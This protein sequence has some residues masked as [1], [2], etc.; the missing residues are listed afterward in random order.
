M[1][2]AQRTS[3]KSSFLDFYPNF[4]N[5]RRLIKNVSQKYRNYKRK[6]CDFLH[7]GTGDDQIRSNYIKCSWVSLVVG[8]LRRVIRE[9]YTILIFNYD[10]KYKEKYIYFYVRLLTLRRVSI[11][12]YNEYFQP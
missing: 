10:R 9:I 12:M 8:T 4:V 6:V 1:N 5:Q 7:R 2:Y 3:I 11:F